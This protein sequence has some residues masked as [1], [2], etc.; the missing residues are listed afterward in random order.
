MERKGG[1]DEKLFRQAFNDNREMLERLAY[2]S[3]RDREAARDIVS[4]VFLKLWEMR[5][6]I[7]GDRLMPYIYVSVK[8]ACVNY[9]RDSGSHKNVHDNIRQR[10]QSAME[11]YTKAMESCNPAELYVEDILGICRERLENY[12]PLLRLIYIKSRVDGM[13]YKEIAEALDISVK[14]VDN[15]LQAVLKDLRI[16]LADY[17][18]AFILAALASTVNLS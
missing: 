5:E 9:R 11:F 17:L 18:H 10:E 6:S 7:D 14:K 4:N 13:S 15:S 1:C 8:N 12:P 2:F 3:V 16:A